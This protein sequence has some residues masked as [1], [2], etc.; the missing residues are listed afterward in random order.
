MIAGSLR[1][2]LA[3]T[4]RDHDETTLQKQGGGLAKTGALVLVWLVG[5]EGHMGRRGW[6]R[7]GRGGVGLGGG[8]AGGGCAGGGLD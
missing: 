7:S 4:A 1:C 5:L 3:E 2:Y 8:C 6:A